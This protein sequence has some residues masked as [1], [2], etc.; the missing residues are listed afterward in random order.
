MSCSK[1]VIFL[2]N[3]PFNFVK[4]PRYYFNCC[5]LHHSGTIM[6][7]LKQIEIRSSSSTFVFNKKQSRVNVISSSHMGFASCAKNVSKLIPPTSPIGDVAIDSPSK[8]KSITLQ[9]KNIL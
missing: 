6:S 1:H 5:A 2:L 9:V 4:G 3:N 8:F 7:G